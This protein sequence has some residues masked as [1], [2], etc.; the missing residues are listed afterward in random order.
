M[1]EPKRGP[2]PQIV[3]SD[4]IQG[5]HN[6]DL[7]GTTKRLVKSGFWKKQ[8]IIV[9]LPAGHSISPKVS[10]THWNLAFPPNNAHVKTLAMGMEVGEAYSQTISHILADKEL[11]T[12]EYIL[13]IEH[14]NMPPP[15]GILRLVERMENNPNLD[16]V[17]GLYFT[18]GEAGVA[19][20]WGDP[21]DPLDNFRPQ[22]P[23]PAGGLKL[24][25][26][27]GMG[28]N[29]WRLKMFK[30]KKLRQP[31]FKT[32]TKEG[33]MT[34]DL[35]FWNDA[36]RHGYKCAVDCSVRVGHYDEVNDIVW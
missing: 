11:S 15:D 21:S 10:L 13:T 6:S 36:R 23:D 5:R 9:I 2:K 28:F 32:L 34:Q 33:I 22:P 24:C 16:C 26:G 35:Y 17:G 27:T 1:E 8:R 3:F 25:C 4:I 19:Q 30:D 20:I 14:D 7:E 29:L 12:W 31:W 18:K